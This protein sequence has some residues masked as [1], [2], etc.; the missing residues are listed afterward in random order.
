MIDEFDAACVAALMFHKEEPEDDSDVEEIDDLLVDRFGIDVCVFADLLERLLPFCASGI[1][2][3]TGTGYR[4][5]AKDGCFIVKTS[6][7]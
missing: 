2:P 7:N 4:G 5:F 3:A 6:T 1:S